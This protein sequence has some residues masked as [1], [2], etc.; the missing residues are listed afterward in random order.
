MA[1]VQRDRPDLALVI[2]GGETLFDYRDYRAATLAR[3]AELAVSVELLGPVAQPDL[4]SLFAAAS[5][6]AF[7]STKEGFGMAAMEA[8]AAGVPVVMR[9]CLSLREVFDGAARFIDSVNDLAVAILAAAGPRVPAAV[10][11]G[12]DLAGRY[13]WAGAAKAHLEFYRAHA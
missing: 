7:P 11:V 4:P 12:R 10:T 5:V 9:D 6:F 3:A 13:T 8:L 2:A 1:I